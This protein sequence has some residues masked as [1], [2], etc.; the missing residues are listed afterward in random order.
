MG[1]ELTVWEVGKIFSQPIPQL[2]RR[3]HCPFRKHKRRDKS[4]KIFTSAGTGDVLF[5]CFSCDAPSNVGDAV[6]LYAQFSSVDRK[7][8]W[9]ELRDRGYAVPGLDDYERR[10]AP[11][12]VDKPR[13]P[14]RGV[15]D[16]DKILPFALGEWRKLSEGRLGAVERF[17]ELRGL[18]AAALRRHDVVDVADD[19]VGFGYRDPY[20]A[21]P[22]RVKCRPVY[23]KTFW[24]EPRS[25]EG[26]AKALS[27]LYLG[28]DLRYPMKRG[29][30]GYVII[31]EGEP[32]TLTLRWMGLDNVVSLPDG[33]GSAAKVSLEP[34]CSPFVL[35]LVSTD[36]D[37]EGERAYR[38]LRERGWAMG[39]MIARV[40]WQ[41]GDKTF[42]DAN[43]ALLG[44]MKQVE[45]ESCLGKAAEFAL[46]YRVA[47]VGR[48][49]GDE[50]DGGAAGGDRATDVGRPLL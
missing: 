30:P 41:L 38:A 32:D 31:T 45:F 26:E 16:P 19:V 39:L 13:V 44:G 24:I 35:W 18:D 23:R 28:H 11:V 47:V 22:C 40:R 36:E 14:V 49:R 8:A 9:H 2:G 29:D 27:P 20:T 25:E 21:L 15:E 42:K 34:I 12:R 37:E 7:T 46:G 10:R 48:R 6:S 4:F 3:G 5:K 17:A 43:E 50:H 1:K 33:C